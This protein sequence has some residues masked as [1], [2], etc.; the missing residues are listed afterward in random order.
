M[1]EQFADK[2]KEDERIKQG[3]AARIQEASAQNA[4]LD[5]QARQAYN[6]ARLSLLQYNNDIENAKIAGRAQSL[7]DSMTQSSMAR[8]NAM[9]NS[10]NAIGAAITGTAQG[11]G[12]I[13]SA[14]QKAKQDYQNVLL[15]ADTESKVNAVIMR[16][17]RQTAKNLYDSFIGSNNENYKKYAQQ[18]DAKFGFSNTSITTKLPVVKTTQTRIPLAGVATTSLST[19]PGY[20]YNWNKNSKD[21][22]FPDWQKQQGYAIGL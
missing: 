12:N 17:D 11:F 1:G 6:N 15:G 19:T 22:S 10:A 14:N 7:A 13:Y 16:N 5:A 21:I 18:L 2:H 8:S 9:V 20:I 3:N 4:Q